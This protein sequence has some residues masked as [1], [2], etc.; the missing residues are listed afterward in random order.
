MAQ[1]VSRKKKPARRTSVSK[2]KLRD[3]GESSA[4]KPTQVSRSQLEEVIKTRPR[5]D[6]TDPLMRHSAM[7]AKGISLCA[8]LVTLAAFQRG[9]KVTFHYEF[10]TKI[11][12]YRNAQM[13]GHRGEQFTISDGSRT[14]TFSRTL[15]DL[16]T[17]EALVIGED[18]HLTKIALKKFGVLTPDGIVC[19]KT[20]RALL[21][22][23]L[24]RN[25]DRTFVV[26]PFDGTMGA[27]VYTNLTRHEVLEKIETI[28]SKRII[29]EE[30][31]VG[32]EYRSIVAGY[33]FVGTFV[34]TAA[35]VVG[36]GEKTIKKLISIKN[37]R[38]HNN[39]WLS[40]NLISDIDAI[41]EF[42]SKSGRSLDSIPAVGEKVTLLG[43][44]N[45]SRGGDPLPATS[46]EIVNKIAQVSVKACEA[47]K[48]PVSGL[49]IILREEGGVLRPYVI[50]LNQKPHI[51]A[52]TFPMEGSG[53][54]NIVGEA[55]IDFY[56]PETVGNRVFSRLT[57][58]FSVIRN[59]LH[60]TQVSEISLP[61]IENDWSVLR[62]EIRGN[63]RMKTLQKIDVA[64]KVSGVYVAKAKG[65]NDTIH[66]CISYSAFVFQRFLS[67]LPEPLRK[68]FAEQHVKQNP[69]VN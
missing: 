5:V 11:K 66:L 29:V 62:I 53:P 30:Y 9:L 49:D 40:K 27:D 37:E 17:P 2:A 35:N 60:S 64:A 44:S 15:G 38:R 48:I 12:K 36:D 68:P 63:D 55:I 47:L 22:K 54:G 10:A 20:Q 6:F 57:Y 13:Q 31:I 46:V 33:R 34:K 14:H 21:E 25:A 67:L 56:F 7:Q 58:D 18:K 45:G 8:F 19:D 41:S 61:L 3:I 59:A 4:Q 16:T 28:E 50:E 69:K 39:P 32:D 24:N 26:K 23:F 52:I 65:S 42:L 51:G 1:F 43:T